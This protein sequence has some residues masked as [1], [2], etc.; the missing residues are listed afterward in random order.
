MR[1]V[2]VKFSEPIAVLGD[3]K[4]TAVLNEKYK[5]FADDLLAREKPPSASTIKYLIEQKKLADRY[6]EPMYGFARDMAWKAGDEAFINAELAEKWQD[7]GI[8]MIL[9]DAPGKKA[10]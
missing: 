6:G 8:C 3:P 10:A 2:K 1:K 7:C 4:P 9:E 5:K